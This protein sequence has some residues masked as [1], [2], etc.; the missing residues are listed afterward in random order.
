M[1]V[2][3]NKFIMVKILLDFFQQTASET[4]GKVPEGLCP[5]CWGEQE[6]DKQIRT[7][8]KDKQ[9]DINNH[10]ENHAFIQNFVINNISGIKLRKKENSMQCPRCEQ[11]Y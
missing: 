9:I 6:Y 8:Y 7:L 4:K 5:N 3:L 1:Q 11:K 10:D 2:L